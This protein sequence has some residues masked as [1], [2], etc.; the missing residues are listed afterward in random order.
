MAMRKKYNSALLK[1][2]EQKVSCLVIDQFIASLDQRLQAYKQISSQFSYFSNLKE[3]SSDE[4]QAAAEQLVRSYPDYLDITFIDELCQFVTFA[5]IFTDEEPKNISTELFLYR[6]IIDKGVQDTFPNI[7]IAL[8]IYLILMVS[9]CSGER[10][11][12]KLKLI[13]NRLRTSMKQKRLVNLAIMS[14]E[15]DILRELDFSDIISD[16]AARKSRKVSGL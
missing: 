16:F 4:L 7:E 14:I 11:F 6:L 8:R 1:N 13:E 9:N 3:L 15:S 5:N 10:S 12:S 2:T